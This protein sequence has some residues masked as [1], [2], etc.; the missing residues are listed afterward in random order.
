MKNYNHYDVVKALQKTQG[1]SVDII[2]KSVGIAKDTSK[3]GLKSW[4]KIDYL[5]KVHGYHL[6]WYNSSA[7][8]E[9]YQAEREVQDDINNNIIDV[10]KTKRESKI[11][12]AAMAKSTMKR[13]RVK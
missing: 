1:V 4:G 11:N 5:C 12:M 13:I 7:K 6:G 9:Y 2:N 8:R 10:K 3:I